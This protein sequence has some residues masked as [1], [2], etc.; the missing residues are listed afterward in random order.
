MSKTI[1]QLDEDIAKLKKRKQRLINQEKQKERKARTRRLIQIG[2]AVESVLGHP[3]DEKDIPLLIKF[4]KTQEDRGN[5]FSRAMI[6]TDQGN[7]DKFY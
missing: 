5:Y 7:S 6:Q 3:I 1:E 4:L 2:G